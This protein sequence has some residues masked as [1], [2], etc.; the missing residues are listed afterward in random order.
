MRCVCADTEQRYRS[1]GTDA[2]H[3]ISAPFQ[4]FARA[5]RSRMEGRRESGFC[6]RLT[7]KRRYP[8]EGW[9][10]GGAR[11]D[12]AMRLRGKEMNASACGRS[13]IALVL[14]EGGQSCTRDR[15]L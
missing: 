5:H 12:I 9:R 15:F 14:F 1:V 11:L 13:V 6:F 2:L 10:Y 3:P 8:V 7:H 4:S